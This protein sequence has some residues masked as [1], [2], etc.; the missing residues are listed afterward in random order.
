MRDGMGFIV[1]AYAITWLGLLGYA[2]RLHRL[3]E[4]M[5]AEFTEASRD[6]A[7]GGGDRD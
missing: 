1:A 3:S 7:S 5:Q 2:L 4:R 6:A